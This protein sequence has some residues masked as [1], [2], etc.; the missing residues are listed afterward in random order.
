MQVKADGQDALCAIA[1]EEVDVKTDYVRIEADANLHC[2]VGEETFG[3]VNVEKLQE[4]SNEALCD[5]KSKFSCV[6]V[7]IDPCH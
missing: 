2:K 5:C 4:K 6:E 3:D 7:D 1:V